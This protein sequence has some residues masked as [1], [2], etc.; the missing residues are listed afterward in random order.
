M[1]RTSP[2]DE[3]D[4]TDTPARHDSVVGAAGRLA[5]YPA[6]AAVRASR[7]RIESSVESVLTGP[8][9]ARI[10]DAALAGPF[11]EE[12]AR[13]LVQRRVIE[14]MATE[15]AASG[16]LERALA[17]ALE[18]PDVRAALRRALDQQTSNFAGDVAESLRAQARK[19]DGRVDRRSQ[20]A[21]P[22]FA[23]VASRGIALAVDAA[24][25]GIVAACIS[26]MGALI[27]SL[28]GT[29][30]PA[31]FVSLVLAVGWS[32]LAGAYFAG[33]WSLAGQT[34][35]MRLLNIRV[36]APG[37]APL[38][39][40]RAALRVVG[41]ALAIIPCFAGFIPAFFDSR[42]RAMPDLVAET[43]VVEG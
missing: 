39:F 28:V 13:I 9:L 2:F 22:H 37:G 5:L 1:A 16:Q 35:G 38:S 17:D 25:I 23:G 27:A 24:L 15:I 7:T 6:R 31:W 41:L 3:G 29:L 26:A 36:L 40:G 43:T 20:P 4:D 30:R 42:R 10:V 14:R 21:P 12:L 18:R 8:E 32:L 11:P 19:L 33:F 34:P